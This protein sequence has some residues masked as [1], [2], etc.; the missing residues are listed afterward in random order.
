MQFEVNGEWIE[1]TYWFWILTIL[2]DLFTFWI[3]TG[4]AFLMVT[5][6]SILLNIQPSNN[7]VWTSIFI[8]CIIFGFLWGFMIGF[9]VS[10]AILRYL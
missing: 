6:I 2:I 1:T 8:G 10:A 5:G 4:C 9:G 3:W 7:P